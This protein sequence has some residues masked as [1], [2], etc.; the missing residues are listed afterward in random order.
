MPLTR[1]DFLRTALVG[2]AF[3]SLGT[4]GP[5]IL[6]RA[7]LS[8]SEAPGPGPAAGGPAG[9]TILVA[10]QLT[11]GNDGLNTVVPFEDDRY[12]R[13][14]PTLRLGAGDVLPIGTHLGIR[15]GLHPEMGGFREL[16]EAGRASIVQGVGYPSSSR[17][18]EEALRDWQTAVPGDPEAPTGWL[19]RAADEARRAP[20]PAASPAASPAA[21]RPTEGNVPAAFVGSIPRPFVLNAE[22]VIVPSFRSLADWT[23]RAN[24]DARGSRGAPGTFE[25]AVTEEARAASSDRD[26]APSSGDSLLDF[27]RRTADGAARTAGRIAAAIERGDE[28][29]SGGYPDFGLADDLRTLARLIRAETGVRIYVV[30]L[31][32]GGLGGFDNHANQAV[33]HDALLRQLSESLLAFLRDLEGDGLAERV[34]L[35]TYTEFGRTLSENGRRGTDHGIASP[36]LLAGG[37]LRG[38]VH[39]SHPDLGDLEGD[40]PRFHTDYRRLFATALGP[41]LSLDAE[42]ILGSAHRPLEGILA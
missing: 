35:L 26:A 24:V 33:N 18:H 13:S 40:A 7:A 8:A 1:R 3:L 6:G 30:E 20:D 11:G 10:L 5:A 27:V 2:P 38:E 36:V 16:L 34:L 41:W 32:G 31:G 28:P 22:K 15:L 29:G 37:R 19:G 12:A 39:G 4:A 21:H 14:R 25:R 9:E 42:R 17:D 23:L